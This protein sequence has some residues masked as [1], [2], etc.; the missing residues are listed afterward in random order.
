MAESANVP[1]SLRAAIW[2]GSAVRAV[3][4][5]PG[6]NWALQRLRA[7][8]RRFDADVRG[9]TGDG[10]RFEGN[11]G[12]DSNSLDPLL[13]RFTEPELGPI[14]RAALRPG[15]TFVDVG[16]N[17]GTYSL[18]AAHLV[19]R[20]GRV[21]AFEPV[22]A[23]RARL[24][25]NVS[26]N[27]VPQLEIV[28]HG[29]GA[30]PGRTSFFV[31]DGSSG[32]SSRYN[33]SGGTRVEVEIGTLDAVLGDTASPRLMKIDVEGMELEVMRGATRLL[34]SER[35]PMIVFEAHPDHMRAAGTSYAEVRAFLQEH[36]GYEL[37]ALRRTGLTPEPPGLDAPTT[38]D[39]LAARP[40]LA[41]HAQ[42][43][44]ALRSVAF[45]GQEAG[46]H[47][48]WLAALRGR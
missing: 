42:T 47:T 8:A 45:R 21:L 4:E 22:P 15:D 12:A 23:T 37:Y 33:D 39:V 14:L 3:P 19:G 30:E 32:L 27:D 5:M 17:V 11:P 44:A 31:A 36:G 35:A 10:L 6:R 18:L 26:L 48:R 40:D 13:L 28:A 2:L 43:T 9:A 24:E 16:A 41:D 29:L 46:V 25:R 20:E 38:A 7:F 34:G 1:A